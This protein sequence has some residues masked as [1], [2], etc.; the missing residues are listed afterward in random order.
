LSCPFVLFN[1]TFATTPFPKAIN[2]AVPRNS[3][4]KIDIKIIYFSYFRCSLLLSQV[5]LP[6]SDIYCCIE[7][8]PVIA[9]A[10][11]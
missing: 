2:M 9:A 5:A 10:H 4:R 3:L 7:A 6:Q 1:T 8:K 11:G